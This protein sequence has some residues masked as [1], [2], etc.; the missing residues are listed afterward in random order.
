MENCCALSTSRKRYRHCST[1]A[2]RALISAGIWKEEEE[3]DGKKKEEEE[4]EKG[5][6]E[7]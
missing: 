2:S 5:K 3:E 6:K 1:I 4:E 7:E